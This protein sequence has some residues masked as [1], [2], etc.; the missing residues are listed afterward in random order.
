[1]FA[2]NNEHGTPTSTEM[3]MPNLS[4]SV[5]LPQLVPLPVPQ[6]DLSLFRVPRSNIDLLMREFERES[7]ARIVE[8][9]Q[10]RLQQEYE[11]HTRSLMSHHAINRLL[12]EVGRFADLLFTHREFQEQRP[13]TRN[14]FFD[15]RTNSRPEQ[16]IN[17]KRLQ[18]YMTALKERLSETEMAKENERIESRLCDLRCLMSQELPDIP[19]NILGERNIYERSQLKYW[20]E[21]C[22]E[23]ERRHPITRERVTNLDYNIDIGT[24]SEI[25]ALLQSLEQRVTD[26]APKNRTP[27]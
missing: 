8:E 18:D 25:E 21:M 11:E 24:Q 19:V 2:S 17:E 26:L 14:N 22:P 13:S 23:N 20:L 15:N 5:T 1:M 4:I 16:T 9:S 12:P 6:I 7:F 3:T 10:R 27:C